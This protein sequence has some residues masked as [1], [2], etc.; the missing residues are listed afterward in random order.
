MSQKKKILVLTSTFPRWEKD[1]EPRFVFDLCLRLSAYYDLYVIAPHYPGAKLVENHFGLHVRR[2]RYFFSKW[3][4]LAYDGG[5]LSNLKRYP[6]KYL[7]VPLFIL[8]EV[9]AV[10][11]VQRSQRFDLIHAH[12]LI[13]Q[14]LVAII[15]KLFSRSSPILCTS[16]G[17]DLFSL[18]G[19]LLQQLKRYTLS[20][21]QALTVVSQAMRESAVC[22]GI[23]PA[24]VK[25]IPM[26]T[27]LRNCF[28][29]PRDQRRENTLLFVGRLVEKKGVRYLIDAMPNILERHRDAS[30]LIVGSGPEEASLMER[31]A[32][33]GLDGYIRFTGSVGNTQLPELY[34]SCSI[35]V[36]PSVVAEDGDQEGFGLVLV[37]ALGC[38]CTVIATDL[39]AMKDFILDGETGV[40]VSQRDSKLLAEKVCYLLD[41]SKIARSMA[42]RGRQYVLKRYDWDNTVAR[43]K[44]LIDRLMGVGLHKGCVT[45]YN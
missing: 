7:L 13:P 16:H 4:T 35:F 33:L 36:F 29:P 45:S 34:Q 24:S 32:E 30:L 5:I 3:E 1:H 12:W 18:Q 22:L 38:E 37:E 14:G 21:I 2:F 19:R 8:A 26:G 23:S 41:H 25:V 17:G 11:R 28:V 27:N 31:T 6:W 9:I 10:I 44:S 42:R 43:Y 15:T 39:P 20:H 40:I